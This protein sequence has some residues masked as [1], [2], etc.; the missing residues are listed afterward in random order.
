MTGGV[1][2]TMCWV[3]LVASV[4]SDAPLLGQ[5]PPSDAFAGVYVGA[6]AGPVSYNTHITFDGLDDPAGRGGFLYGAVSGYNR[7]NGRWILGVEGTLTRASVPGPYTFDPAITGFAELDLR[8]DTGVGLDGRVGR[9]WGDRTLVYAS[10]GY[11]VVTQSV[12]LDGVL[13]SDF[14]GGAEPV[15]SG[16]V[17]YGAGIEVAIGERVG[18][19]FSLRRLGG[20]D[21]SAGDFGTAVSSVGL[22]AFDVQPS[23]DQLLVGARYRF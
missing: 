7:L 21:L 2:R 23:Q 17:Q 11:S 13:L 10:V 4:V 9:L 6:A 18:L 16:T 1:V 15:T 19:R 22:S 8:H 20:H 3:L 5:A 12:R 14:E